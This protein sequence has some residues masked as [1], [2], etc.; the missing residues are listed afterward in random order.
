MFFRE[1]VESVTLLCRRAWPGLRPLFVLWPPFPCAAATLLMSGELDW[2]STAFADAAAEEEDDDDGDGEHGVDCE[3]DEG[4]VTVSL[5]AAGG[6][7]SSG[8][9]ADARF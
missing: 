9:G 7:D 8:V 5:S 3:G 1:R 2:I 4:N 6:E